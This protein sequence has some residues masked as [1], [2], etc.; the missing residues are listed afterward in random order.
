MGVCFRW[1]DKEGLKISQQN[2]PQ[3][4]NWVKSTLRYIEA[5]NIEELGGKKIENLSESI[6]I[7][8]VISL[9]V[10]LTDKTE[11]LINYD[12]MKLMKKNCIIINSARGGIINEKDLDKALNES[13]IFGAAIAVSYT[14]LRAH[15]T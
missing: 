1:T 9:H 3:I 4:T 12:L 14:H 7:M 13:L 6:K 5:S 15:E 11:N 2:L 10:P 8:D